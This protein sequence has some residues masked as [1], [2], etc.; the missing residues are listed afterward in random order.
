MVTRLRA[1]HH[2][3]VHLK[4]VHFVISELYLNK[5]VHFKE[6]GG[7]VKDDTEVWSLSQK[8]RWEEGGGAEV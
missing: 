4:N 7:R 1:K 6:S 2:W 5:T 8:L 3:I